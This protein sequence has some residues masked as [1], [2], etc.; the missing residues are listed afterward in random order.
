M[1]I[2]STGQKIKKL[3]KELGLKQ[4]D[5]TNEEVTRS[6]ISMIENDKRALSWQTAKIISDCLNHY[7]K[8]IGKSI[9]PEYLMETEEEQAKNIIIVQ[10]KNLESSMRLGNVNQLHYHQSIE[11]LMELANE[12]KVEK[13][14]ADLLILRGELSYY[15]LQYNNALKDYSDSLEYNLAVKDVEQVARIYNL[16]GMCYQNLGL[17]EQ[18]LIYYIKSY[19]IVLEFKTINKDDMKVVTIFNIISCYRKLKKYDMVFQYI[20]TFKEITSYDDNYY[21]E[22]LLMEGNTYRDLKNYEKTQKIYEKLLQRAEKQKTST[23]FFIYINFATLFREKGELDKALFYIEEAFKLED[24]ISAYHTPDLYQEQAKC[25]VLLEETNN[26]L[27]ALKKGLE[28]AELVEKHEIITA[29]L[30]SFTELYMRLKDYDTA[31]E[32][33]QKAENLIT[34]KSMNAKVNELYSYYAELYCEIEEKNKCVEYITK[35]RNN[36]LK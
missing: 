19:E 36:Q 30:F 33:L 4:D 31:K 27:T 26:A 3:R 17:D 24:R 25:Y 22:V 14:F 8:N 23:L 13:E 18:A 5:I 16:I 20:K 6:L 10:I 21:D 32:Y 34:F 11:W 1:E 7:Y 15:N 28:I 12:W 29:F 35:L 9:T 2:L